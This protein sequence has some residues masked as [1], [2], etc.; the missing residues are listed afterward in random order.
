MADQRNLPAAN[1]VKQCSACGHNSTSYK[2]SFIR[3]PREEDKR[4]MWL[5]RLGIVEDDEP[6][7]IRTFFVCQDHF[8]VSFF[9]WN[10]PFPV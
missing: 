10:E 5:V 6:L 8:D 2:G 4:R 7:P 9:W 3:V 1:M